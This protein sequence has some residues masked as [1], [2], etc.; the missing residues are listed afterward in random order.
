MMD[1]KFEGENILRKTGKLLDIGINWEKNSCR[2]KVN[3]ILL[4]VLAIFM[5]DL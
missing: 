2:V 3:H 1:L 4:F 5:M